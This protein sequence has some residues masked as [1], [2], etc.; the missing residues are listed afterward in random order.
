MF[1]ATAT[2]TATSDFDRDGLSDLGEYFAGTDPKNRASLLTVASV[3]RTDENVLLRWPSELNRFYTVERATDLSA[4]FSVVSAN[5][6]A[7]VPENVLSVPAESGR[8]AS[9]Y[10]VRVEPP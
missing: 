6:A 5:L 1:N 8:A 9:F 10:R 2:A 4:G 3:V 7:T